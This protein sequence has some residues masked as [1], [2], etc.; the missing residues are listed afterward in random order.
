LYFKRKK[1]FLLLL[2]KKGEKIALEHNEI[3]NEMM[4]A[5]HEARNAG[6]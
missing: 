3:R 5:C 1:L 2:K 6:K 4:E